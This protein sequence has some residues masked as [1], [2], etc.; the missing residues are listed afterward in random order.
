MSFNNK[1]KFEKGISSP[2]E[3]YWFG[4]LV[5]DGTI[6]ENRYR[7]KLALQ[8]RDKK[9][10]EKFI[11]FLGY[12]EKKIYLYPDNSLCEV[13]I[14]NKRLLINLYHLGLQQNKVHKTH[15]GLIPEKYQRDFVRGLFDADGT[16]YMSLPKNKKTK[17]ACFH[18]CGTNNLL[19]GV[20]DVFIKNIEGIDKNTGCISKSEGQPAVLEYGGRWFTD[21]IGHYLYDGAEIYLGRKYKIF[22]KL[23]RYNKKHNRKWKRFDKKAI[24]RI[25]QL[26]NEGLVQTEIA[27]KF[28]ISQPFV[29]RII[30]KKRYQ[31]YT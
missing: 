4:F 12:K 13:R 20:K 29:S 7:L 11:K 16:V 22:Q 23:F 30:N 9:H 18:I 17:Q 2:E 8:K 19:E 21:K 25:R 6:Y 1:I 14:D 15:K 10:I 3:S 5:G 27:K 28:N 24:Y 26:Y 31:I